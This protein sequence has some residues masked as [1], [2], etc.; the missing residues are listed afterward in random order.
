MILLKKKAGVILTEAIVSMWIFLFLIAWLW[1]IYQKVNQFDEK[2]NEMLA[3]S[4]Y[5]RISNSLDFIKQRSM[6]IWIEESW[7]WSSQAIKYP[8][9]MRLKVTAWGTQTL[10]ELNGGYELTDTWCPVG[11]VRC[12]KPLLA[13]VYSEIPLSS[14]LNIYTEDNSWI[15]TV[16]TSEKQLVWDLVWLCT[17]EFAKDCLGYRL[18]ISDLAIWRNPNLQF[19][20]SS[21][22]V[23]TIKVKSIKVIIKNWQ[24]EKSYDYILSLF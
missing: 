8:W 1:Y 12:L 21:G 13:W 5:T 17:W 10:N 23:E 11:I 22:V 15:R 4:T 7:T 2:I 20:N 9:W 3:Y 18:E 19:T 14:E 24:S 6:S 16:K